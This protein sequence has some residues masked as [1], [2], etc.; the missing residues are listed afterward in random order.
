MTNPPNSDFQA[1]I[2]NALAGRRSIP[3]SC[4]PNPVH[5]APRYVITLCESLLQLI[6]AG[7]NKTATL[8]ELLV[9]ERSCTGSD[10]ATKLALRSERL[11]QARATS[12]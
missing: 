4:S 6:Y 9:L 11:S 2:D 10:Y 7:G 8:Q 1:A 5:S 12:N 3:N